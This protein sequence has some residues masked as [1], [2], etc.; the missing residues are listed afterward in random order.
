MSKKFEIIKKSTG[1]K[2]LKEIFKTLDEEHAEQLMQLVD[3]LILDVN[4]NAYH[5]SEFLLKEI[6]K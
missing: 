6:K 5:L 3:Y 1:Y 4:G 2:N